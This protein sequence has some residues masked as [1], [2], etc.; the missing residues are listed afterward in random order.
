V[1]SIARKLKQGGYW[2]NKGKK[3]RS[4]PAKFKRSGLDWNKHAATSLFYLPVKK[5]GSFY[6]VYADNR[7]R[8]DMVA[9]ARDDA[10]LSV[11]LPPKPVVATK[12]VITISEPRQINE[13]KKLDAIREWQSAKVTRISAG[14]AEF[15]SFAL[16]LYYAGLSGPE[17]EQELHQ[18]YPDGRSPNERKAQITSIVKSLQRYGKYR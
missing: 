15:W 7:R 1:G 4:C 5:E 13:A 11:L 18:H 8:L 9:W 10:N 16:S 17:I 14:N 6:R 3:G 12:P 2:T